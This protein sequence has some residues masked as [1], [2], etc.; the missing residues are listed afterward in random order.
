MAAVAVTPHWTNTKGGNSSILFTYVGFLAFYVNQKYVHSTSKSE[1]EME[2]LQLVI[3]LTP[4]YAITIIVTYKPPNV[5]E[6]AYLSQFSDIIKSVTSEALV[7]LR[8]WYS[9]IK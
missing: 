9:S 3:H 1:T 2:T 5:S 4:Q 8:W 6:S 7:I